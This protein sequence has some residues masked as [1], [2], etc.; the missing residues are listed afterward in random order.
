MAAFTHTSSLLVKDNVKEMGIAIC[1][2]YHG[3]VCA[4]QRRLS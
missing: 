1:V 2:G 4:Y 3:T